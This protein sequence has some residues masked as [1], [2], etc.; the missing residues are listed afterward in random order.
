MSTRP[1]PT[2]EELAALELKM[3]NQEKASLEGKL[4]QENNQSL[5]DNPYSEESEAVLYTLWKVAFKNFYSEDY[6]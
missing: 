5:E 1:E 6:E 2:A 4:A 3:Q